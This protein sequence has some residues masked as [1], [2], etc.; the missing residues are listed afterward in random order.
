M[1][2]HNSDTTI[3]DWVLEFD[4]DAGRTS[5]WNAEIVSHEGAHY[6]IKNVQH[7]SNIEPGQSA[8][9]GFNGGEGAGSTELRGYKL[10]SYGL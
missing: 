4:F 1:V 2:I 3:E 6:I 5:I 7:N 10:Y 9:V 8:R